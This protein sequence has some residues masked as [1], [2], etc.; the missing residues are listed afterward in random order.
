MN[1]RNWRLASYLAA[2]SL[3]WCIA[4]GLLLYFLP[5]GTSVTGSSTGEEVETGGERLFTAS[6]ASVWPLI[7]PMLLC[8]LATWCAARHHRSLFI[9]ATVLLAVFAFLS[10]FS[11]GFAYWPAL[12]LL[13]IGLAALRPVRQTPHEGGSVVGTR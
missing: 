9:I 5:W 7:V 10:G 11:I 3:V 8:G 6:L 13:A 12:L 1:W 4:A 2:A